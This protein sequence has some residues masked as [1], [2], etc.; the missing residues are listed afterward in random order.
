MNK[1]FPTIFIRGHAFVVCAKFIKLETTYGW[2][3]DGCGKC[4][5]KVKEEDG[6][7]KCFLCKKTP[8]LIQPRSPSCQTHVNLRSLM[9]ILHLITSP[10]YN[11]LKLH[12]VV[13]DDSGSM[14]IVFWDKLA[15]QLLDYTATQLE[16]L[17]K[18]VIDYSTLNYV[19]KI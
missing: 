10:Q 7:L 19:Y 11:R 13:S 4:S 18:E 8:N 9:H 14:S 16:F 3:Y 1:F 17:L 2:Y 6:E 15:T 12:Y 5:S